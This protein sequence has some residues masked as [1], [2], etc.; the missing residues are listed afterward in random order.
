LICT[1]AKSFLFGAARAIDFTVP[2]KMYPALSVNGDR[3]WGYVAPG[4][5]AGSCNLEG[6]SASDGREI[7]VKINATTDSFQHNMSKPRF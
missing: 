2:A 1:V 4:G 7:S 5:I 3:C 6:C